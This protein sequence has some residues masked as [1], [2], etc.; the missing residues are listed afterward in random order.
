MDEQE[1]GKRTVK[2]TEKAAEERKAKQIQARRS[3][4]SQLTSLKR[5]IEQLMEDDANVNTV[6]NKLRVD[7]SGLQEE[8]QELNSGLQEFL[9]E[10]EYAED[11]KSWFGPKND[12][13]DDFFWGCEGWMKD[14]LT[15]AEQAEECEGHVAPA[16]SRSMSS[17][18]SIRHHS[19]SSSQCRSLV[20]SSSVRLKAE[21]ERAS[22]K[23]KAAALKEKLAIEKEEAGWHA[24]KKYMEV[25]L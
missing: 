21:M 9:D 12:L 20:S 6:K 8:F 19:S 15:R 18:V 11:Q 7:F 2:M 14:V 1:S 5:Q 13:M 4:L 24:E 25:Q 10:E 17:K 22:L 16:D 3:K 23:A